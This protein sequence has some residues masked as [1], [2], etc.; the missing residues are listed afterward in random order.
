MT[1]KKHKLILKKKENNFIDN[2][3]NEFSVNKLIEWVNHLTSWH[4]Y[5]KSIMS[6]CKLLICKVFK[7]VKV[8]YFL[9]RCTEVE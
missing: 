1:I 3:K 2:D 9:L 5:C 8:Q 6:L 4:V 7:G